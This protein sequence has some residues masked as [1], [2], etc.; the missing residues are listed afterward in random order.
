MAQQLN[1]NNYS[2][3]NDEINT[4]SISRSDFDKYFYTTEDLREMRINNIL[5]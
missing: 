3:I 5:K 1:P 2:T 4:Y